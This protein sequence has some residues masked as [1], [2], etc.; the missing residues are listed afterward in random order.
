MKTNTDALKQAFLFHKVVDTD[1]RNRIPFAWTSKTFIVF[2]SFSTNNHKPD[3][4]ETAK[5]SIFIQL[6]DSH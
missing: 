1:Y 5:T 6:G 2:Y 4:C 3:F